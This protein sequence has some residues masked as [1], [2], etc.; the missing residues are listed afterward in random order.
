MP[1]RAAVVQFFLSPLLVW[2]SFMSTALSVALYAGALGHY[3]YMNFLGYSALPFLERTE[4]RAQ[5]AGGQAGRR[6]HPCRRRGSGQPGA[7]AWLV[8]GAWR[9]SNRRLPGGSP[10]RAHGTCVLTQHAACCR[11]SCGQ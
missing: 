3:H 8:P 2:K 5:A 6:W 10:A 4:V 1:A 9:C 7:E 11:S